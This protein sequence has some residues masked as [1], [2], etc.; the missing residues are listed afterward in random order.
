MDVSEVIKQR[1][2]ELGMSQ[3]DLARAVGI[4]PRQIRRYE[5]GE[6]QPLLSVALAIADA[7]NISVGELAG[8][9]SEGLR[10]SGEW[11]ASWQTARGGEEKIATQPV[12]MRQ[13]GDRI[14]INALRRGL[15]AEE[16]GYLWSGELHLWDNEL[17]TGWYAA[18]DGSIRS[19]GTIYWI[20]RPGESI[21]TGRWVGLGYDNA[22]MTGWSTAAK[23]SN[24]AEVAMLK[25]INKAKND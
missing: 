18:N 17:L 19:K 9:P 1:R 3:T 4:D 5:A 15:S 12:R 7:L 8:R 14:Y 6:Q 20:V 23:S 24:E 11:W 16:G 10:I 25:L 22:I 13:E 21:M 2:A